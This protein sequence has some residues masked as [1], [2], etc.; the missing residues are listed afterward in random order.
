[1]LRED[2]INGFQILSRHHRVEVPVFLKRM[3]AFEEVNLKTLTDLPKILVQEEN[4]AYQTANQYVVFNKH[5]VKMLSVIIDYN[6]TMKLSPQLLQVTKGLH[7]YCES[8]S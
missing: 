3:P 6:L 1:M 7:F 2:K 8:F 5:N 4:E